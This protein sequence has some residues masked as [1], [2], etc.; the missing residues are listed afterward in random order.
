MSAFRSVPWCLGGEFRIAS[1]IRDYQV[2]LVDDPSFVSG[3]EQIPH[4]YYVVD[5]NV[6]RLYSDGCL[7]DI[8]RERVFVQPI[9]EEIKSLESVQRLYDRLAEYPA[10]RNLTLISI[11]GGILQDITGFVAST[12]YRG[13]NWLFVPTTLL[14]QADSCIG[15]KTSLNYKRYKNLIGTYYPPCEIFIHIPFLATLEPRDFASGLGE[16]IKL[17]IMGGPESLDSFIAA[18]PAIRQRD[19]QAL[20]TAILNSLTIKHSYIATDEFDQGRR[21][22]LNFGHCFGHA[23]ETTSDFALTHGQAVLVG[24]ILANIAARNRG[25]LSRNLEEELA[26][27]LLLPALDTKPAPSHLAASSLDP[28]AVVNAMSKDKKRTGQGLALVVLKDGYELQKLDDFTPAE[29]TAALAELT[30]MLNDER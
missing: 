10:K 6:W 28:D 20:R 30:R 27:R 13:I 7:R 1:H 3:F 26:A 23:L 21:N 8:D 18:Q 9:R 17:H 22:L 5:E 19:P 4:R 12:L 16:V 24:I 14:A 11:G 2:R 29:A 25:L 15:A